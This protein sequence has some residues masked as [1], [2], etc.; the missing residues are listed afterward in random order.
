MPS[1]GP[2]LDPDG[3]VQHK[4]VSSVAAYGRILTLWERKIGTGSI[5]CELVRAA[6]PAHRIVRLIADYQDAGIEVQQLVQVHNVMEEQAETARLERIIRQAS[7][8]PNRDAY[9][10]KDAQAS[11]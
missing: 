4:P 7:I 6:Q 10:Q 5:R 9:A 11:I 8:R 1:Y 3:V 2:Q